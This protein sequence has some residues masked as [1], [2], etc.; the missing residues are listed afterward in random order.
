MGPKRLAV[1]VMIAVTIQAVVAVIP[2]TANYMASTDA[3]HTRV[4]NGGEYVDLVLD[5]TSGTSST[6]NFYHMMVGSWIC[7]RFW[8]DSHLCEKDTVTYDK[9]QCRRRF[10]LCV[11]SVCI[12]DWILVYRRFF[13]TC[14]SDAL[15][16]I[17]RNLNGLMFCY[18]AAA[19]F[20]SKST[21]L[22]GSIGMGIKLVPGNS[23]GTVTAYYVSS[24]W[25]P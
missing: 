15:C 10:N 12:A 18:C 5:R 1:L 2:F 3:T 14:K 19:A 11:C 25:R 8:L 24:N 17:V 13:I 4:V 9:I 6:F 20:G 22:F 21:F 7:T 23:A 16:S